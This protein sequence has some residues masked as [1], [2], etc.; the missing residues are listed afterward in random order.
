MTTPDFIEEYKIEESL[1]DELIKYWKDNVEYKKIG[2]CGNGNVNKNIKDSTDVLF[3]NDTNNQ[4][5][6]GLFSCLSNCVEGYMKKYNFAQNH[7]I[8]TF[9]LNIIQR[10]NKGTGYKLLHYE[11]ADRYTMNRQLVYMVYLNTLKNGGTHFPYQNKTLD[12][13]KGKLVIW[14]SDF[15]HPHVGVISNEK[16]KYIAT[17][18]FVID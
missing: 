11:R 1:C 13:V 4:H 3:Y 16:E 6:K 10:Y 15:T 2:E 18:W 5:L 7:N 9:M 8:H 14:P 17:G 12:A